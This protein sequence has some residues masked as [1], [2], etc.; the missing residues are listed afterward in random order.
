MGTGT[1]G[2]GGVWII[3]QIIQRENSVRYG[4]K[5][6]C[7]RTVRGASAAPGIRTATGRQQRALL[8]APGRGQRVFLGP[9]VWFNGRNVSFSPFPTCKARQ[10]VNSE[11]QQS[12]LKGRRFGLGEATKAVRAA[13]MSSPELIMT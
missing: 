10:P 7:S 5:V 13:G 11:R 1:F 12:R 9:R 4:R 8:R 6:D 2:G 3:L